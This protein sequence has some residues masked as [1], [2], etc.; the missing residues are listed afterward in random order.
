MPRY[1][2][3]NRTA[4]CLPCQ[5]EW[6]REISCFPAW[7]KSNQPTLLTCSRPSKIGKA[8]PE[9]IRYTRSLTHPR[10][11]PSR[12]YAAGAPFIVDCVAGCLDGAA[13][14]DGGLECTGAALD[15]FYR[16]ATRRSPLRCAVGRT[17]LPRRNGVRLGQNTAA[18]CH[19]LGQFPGE[20]Q[21]DRLSPEILRQTI[22]KAV[23]DDRR[24]WRGSMVIGGGSGRP[25]RDGMR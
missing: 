11:V 13:G 25:S 15:G 2:P 6:L 14:R 18:S 12:P 3:L 24:R 10:A 4:R 8:S 5:D 19:Y 7:E 23:D 22:R 9:V 21:T 1:V 20:S 17:T 16:R